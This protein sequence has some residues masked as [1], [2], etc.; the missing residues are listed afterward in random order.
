MRATAWTMQNSSRLPGAPFLWIWIC[1]ILILSSGSEQ[2]VSAGV[3]P[4]P[5]PEVYIVCP[6]LLKLAS[7]V[8]LS[9][10]D[11]APVHEGEAL[12]AGQ[13]PQSAGQATQFSVLAHA[14][15]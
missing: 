13:S 12:H 3:W 10:T 9:G 8:G 15:S 1:E 6:A 14:P 11:E 7:A 4:K 2:P 5:T